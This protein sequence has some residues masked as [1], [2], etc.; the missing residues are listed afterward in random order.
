MLAMRA[1]TRIL[2][3]KEQLYARAPAFTI[4]SRAFTSLP[5]ISI[6]A[7]RNPSASLE[8]RQAVGSALHDACRDVGFFYVSEHGLDEQLSRRVRTMSREWFALP[9]IVK[10]E[11][12][13]SSCKWR[14][15]RGYQALGANVTRY[16][17]GYARDWHEAIDL[18]KDFSESSAEVMAKRPLHG[19]NPW[20]T[21][22][23]GYKETLQTYVQEC[24]ELGAALLRG[25]SLGLGLPEEYFAG[26]RAGDPFWVMR[27]IHYPPLAAAARD[28]HTA[29]AAAS[30]ALQ[31][32]EVDRSVQLSC[33]EHSDY[34]LL[35]IVNQDEELSALQVKN[36]AGEW[37]DAAPVPGTFV[38]NVGDMF[39]VWTNGLYQPTVHRVVNLHSNRHRVSVPFFYEPNF[40]TWVEPE[41]RLCSPEN[42]PKYP[43]IMYGDHLQSKVL[44]NFEL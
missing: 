1:T 32:M 37:V 35:T 39:K 16:E 12:A 15:Y 40:D 20:P 14:G 4:C 17:G 19:P 42:P 10:K 33:G 7:L 23:P 34:G 8:E 26:H 5:I 28:D 25:I 22:V 9:E 29:H 30:A 43:G 3:C 24:T 6:A 41:P 18:Y 27:V 38:C 36:A 44:S 11:I 2:K 21:Q 31:G 13:L